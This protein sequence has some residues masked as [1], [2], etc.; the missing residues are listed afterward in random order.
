[1]PRVSVVVAT[2]NA[3]EFIGETIRG[4]LKQTHSDFELIVVDDASSDHTVDRIS[5]FGDE[6]IR[7][8][9][10]PR[11]VGVA[12]ARN[13]GM[14]AATGDYLA[15]NDH[16]DVSLPERLERQVA[17]LG[18]H[19]DVLMVGTGIY[20]LRGRRRTADPMPPASHH[21]LRWCLMTHSPVCHSTMCLRLSDVR[22]A[23]LR[24]DPACDFGDD[25]DLYHRLAA[26]GRLATLQERL[27]EY[28][29]HGGNASILRGD[30]MTTRGAAM[31]QRA[32]QQQ[33]GMRLDPQAFD[34]LWRVFT[35]FSP[36]RSQA[37]LRVA[38]NALATLLARFTSV[39][40][41]TAAQLHEVNDAASRQWWHA[42]S[43]AAGTLG[44]EAL[45][46]FGRIAS[47]ATF[48]PSVP[49]RLRGRLSRRA[50]GLLTTLGWARG[51]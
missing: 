37:E 34:C 4:I 32:H 28:R 10:N 42:V 38:G 18:R 26:S 30:E 9:R 21:V 19:P 6:R 23:G 11:N 1:M 15:T 43:R 51:Q 31:L 16:D 33:L 13:I 41:L 50:R 36:A 24:Y 5:A 12:N 48:T 20:T 49:L 46:E 3:A 27:V 7:L 2:Y 8:I 40:G 29:L 39:M 22:R 17:F 47:L 45:A 25:F 35:M 44:E 14:D